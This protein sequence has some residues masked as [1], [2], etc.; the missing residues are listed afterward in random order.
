MLLAARHVLVAALPQ[1]RVTLVQ[2]GPVWRVPCQ[3]LCDRLETH[4]LKRRRAALLNRGGVCDRTRMVGL[5]FGDREMGRTAGCATGCA[6]GCARCQISVS[7]KRTGPQ[8]RDMKRGMSGVRTALVQ[9]AVR[10][11]RGCRAPGFRLTVRDTWLCGQNIAAREL[12][13]GSLKAKCQTCFRS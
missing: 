7:H 8:P 13:S 1:N 11:A 6:T 9:T 3:I 5:V 10:T 12:P 4:A 2:F